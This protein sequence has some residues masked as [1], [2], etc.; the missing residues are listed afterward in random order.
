VHFGKYGSI[1][2]DS[3]GVVA[4]SK[5][6]VECQRRSRRSRVQEQSG[7][8][9]PRTP[10]TRRSLRTRTDRVYF[11]HFKFKPTQRRTDSI[12]PPPIDTAARIQVVGE[13][14]FTPGIPNA[15]L[16]KISLSTT[17]SPCFQP[18]SPLTFY[19]RHFDLNTSPD[20]AFQTENRP[21]SLF[22]K[23]YTRHFSLKLPRRHSRTPPVTPITFGASAEAARVVSPL[24]SHRHTSHSYSISLSLSSHSC[25]NRQP[26]TP[27]SHSRM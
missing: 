17:P 15:L 1:E 16:Q 7:G 23:I 22:L 26:T 19:R 24:I 5:T 2:T 11:L 27:R 10:S 12:V 21:L 14:P 20:V 3:N 25:L 9:R 13:H 8:T 6:G 18:S 4:F